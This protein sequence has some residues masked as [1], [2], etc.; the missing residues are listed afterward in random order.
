M[1]I[2][3]ES[4]VFFLASVGLWGLLLLV[5]GWIRRAD[6]RRRARTREIEREIEHQ[7]EAMQVES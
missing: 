4:G 1:E 6:R 2:F 7:I 5:V 3:G